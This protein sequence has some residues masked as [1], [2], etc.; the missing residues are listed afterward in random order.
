[1]SSLV[2][3]VVAGITAFLAWMVLPYIVL[4]LAALLCVAIGMA[5]GS[6][7]ASYIPT[8]PSF[9]GLRTRLGV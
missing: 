5:V 2:K 1:M 4:A 6:L 9:S 8:L 3:Y 7:A